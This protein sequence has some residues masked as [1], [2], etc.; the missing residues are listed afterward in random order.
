CQCRYLQDG[1]QAT[2]TNGVPSA[3]LRSYHQQNLRLAAISLE[4]DPLAVRDISSL[5]MA[6]DP[7]E[8]EEAKRLIQ[9]FKKKI[10]T[11]F[12]SKNPTEVYT[13]GIQLFPVSKKG[14]T[15]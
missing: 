1:E 14:E 6:I 9:Q 13:L 2:T 11:L 12:K 10:S 4:R 5:T 8:F 3:A 7:S 15:P